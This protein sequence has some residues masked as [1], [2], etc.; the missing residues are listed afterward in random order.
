MARGEDAGV[1]SEIV[2]KRKDM[3]ATI[4]I[5]LSPGTSIEDAYTEA[6][7]LANLLNVFIDFDFNG[8]YCISH[9]GGDPK[10]GVKHYHRVLEME[11]KDGCAS[12]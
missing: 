12:T 4:K 5:E 10:V 9:P 1:S 7:R 3:I 6:I 8:V 11:I 2:L